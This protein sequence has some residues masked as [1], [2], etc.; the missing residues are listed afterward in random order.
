MN[1]FI[2]DVNRRYNE[3]L[4][5][6]ADALFQSLSDSMSGIEPFLNSGYNELR[7]L[8]AADAAK[9]M[10]ALGPAEKNKL[11]NSM[12]LGI[13]DYGIGH[14]PRNVPT[15]VLNDAMYEAAAENY[16]HSHPLKIQKAIR[17]RGME[18]ENK[19]IK[20]LD[21]LNK[22]TG[23]S[24]PKDYK[25]GLFDKLKRALG[26]GPKSM[27]DVAG[28]IER[29]I[30]EQALKDMDAKRLVEKAVTS[31]TVTSPLK[32]VGNKIHNLTELLKKIK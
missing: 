28:F 24:L 6:S 27:P 32:N 3:K 5:A 22:S 1:T 21:E 20:Y 10:D 8:D 7:S 17:N 11:R 13:G 2:N 4:A 9:L 18:I 25:L 12:W 31:P 26:I 30:G 16:V 15:R 29:N 23:Y 19:A 14:N